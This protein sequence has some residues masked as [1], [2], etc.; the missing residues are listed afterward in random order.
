MCVVGPQFALAPPT[1]VRSRAGLYKN[2]FVPPPHFSRST[3]VLIQF[4]HYF[5]AVQPLGPKLGCF[6][7]I[8]IFRMIFL[9]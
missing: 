5:S 3:K 9:L 7:V 6:S 1:F 8:A 4:V 2:G